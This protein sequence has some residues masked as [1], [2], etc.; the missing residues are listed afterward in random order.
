MPAGYAW[1]QMVT[2]ITYE[3]DAYDDNFRIVTGRGEGR[4]HY[5]RSYSRSTKMENNKKRPKLLRREIGK[6]YCP[7][8]YLETFFPFVDVRDV[9]RRLVMTTY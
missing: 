3:L 9:V 4:K 2:I 7:V 5:N 1:Q 8:S 6:F